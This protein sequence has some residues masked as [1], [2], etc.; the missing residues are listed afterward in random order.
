M[1]LLTICL[2]T[3]AKSIITE[4]KGIDKKNP[5]YSNVK[6]AITQ[7]TDSIEKKTN[8]QNIHYLIQQQLTL[9]SDAMKPFGYFNAEVSSTLYTNASNTQLRFNITPGTPII[10]KD[11]NISI[12]G[13]AS[14]DQDFSDLRKQFPLKKND[15]LNTKKYEDLKKNIKDLAAEKGYLDAKMTESKITINYQNNSAIITIKFES[16]VRYSFGDITFSETPLKESFLKKFLSF[17]TNRPYNLRQIQKTQKNLE[18]SGYFD[19]AIVFSEKSDPI[20]H[21]IPIHINL[22]LSKAQIYNIGA[23]YSTNTKARITLGATI[24]R[25]NSV[26]HSISS[27]V[28]LTSSKNASAQLNYNIP[29][30]NPTKESYSFS[31]GYSHLSQNTG[32]S[33][34]RKVS[35]SKI[36]TFDKLKQI[37]SINALDENYQITNLPHTTTTMLYPDINWIYRNSDDEL[38]P[39]KGYAV[40]S[41]L[42]GTAQQLS[43][44]RSSFFQAK[45]ETKLLQTYQPTNTRFIFHSEIGRTIIDQLENLPL[46]LQL[47][48]GGTNSIRGFSYNAMTGKNLGIASAEIQQKIYGPIYLA[49]FIDAGNASDDP[50]FKDIKQSAGPGIVL[51]LPIGTMELTL[52]YQINSNEIHKPYKIQFAM[53]PTL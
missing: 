38:N 27:L 24:N 46:S 29:G 47:F 31:A 48:A 33:N 15:I 17:Q 21:T 4:I 34:A 26:G 44:Q 43:T 10:I 2:S 36:N 16:G 39:T 3:S 14:K 28:Q 45:F 23:G 5:A 20:H 51:L 6:N 35:A 49:G 32:N 19:R 30:E 12:S 41:H 8:D 11:I 40:S 52:A 9:I 25:L 42:S 53:G 13:E 22:T 1:M 7:I 37:L 50:I 18:K